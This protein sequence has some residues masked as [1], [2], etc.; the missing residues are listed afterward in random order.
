M[1]FNR[2]TLLLI[3]IIVTFLALLFIANKEEYGTIQPPQLIP[4]ADT[5]TRDKPV[6]NFTV[7]VSKN[8]CEGCH[9]SGKNFIPQALSIKPHINGGAYC[10]SCHEISHE[11]HPIDN[12]VTC[13]RCHGGTSPAMPAFINGSIVCNNCHGYPDP[14]TPSNGDLITIHRSRGVTCNTCHTD[15]CTKC[16]L[17]MGTGERWEKRFGHFRALNRP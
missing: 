17:E 15:E 8:I 3:L 6:S 13:E 12:N 5:A 10:L 11:K 4:K 14:L 9:I 1:K 16:H 2:N 7:L